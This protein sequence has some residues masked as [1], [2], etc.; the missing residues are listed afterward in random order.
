M[1]PRNGWHQLRSRVTRNVWF[2]D[3]ATRRPP[4]ADMQAGVGGCAKL[5]RRRQETLTAVSSMTNEV[6]AVESSAP[7]NFSVMV[8]PW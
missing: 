8:W 6:C 1:S 3:M 2:G 4:A 5:R 7:V